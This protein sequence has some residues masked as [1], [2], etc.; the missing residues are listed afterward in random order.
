MT[1]EISLILILAVSQAGAP[2]ADGSL[3][4]SFVSDEAEAVLAL[5]AEQ[6][7]GASPAEAS[8][9]RLFDSRGYR[10]LKQREESMKRGFEDDEFR[11]FVLS[12][13]LRA[14][15]DALAGTLD[16]WRGASLTDAAGRALAYLP[17]GAKLAATIYPVIKPKSNSFVFDLDGDP[18]IFLYLDPDVT[19]AKFAN[20][21]AHELHH[22]GHHAACKDALAPAP[23]EDL[24]GPVSEA[25]GWLGAFGEGVAM[26]AAAGGPDV[27]PHA[28]SPDEDRA[29]WDS[30][31]SRFDQ[32]LRE[33]EA[34]LMDVATGRLS[35]PGKVREAGFRFFGVQGPWYTVGWRMAATVE[36]AYG[37]GALVESLCDM[38]RLLVLYNRA[39][40]P[41]SGAP[42]EE[43]R[44]LWSSG[45]LATLRASAP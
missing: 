34:F 26:L 35:D 8:W 14:R 11:S 28:V 18:S 29:R 12:P 10:R 36:T 7:A 27:H 45:L 16:A 22:V 43:G 38:R 42:P 13:E 41:A 5:L 4:V 15:E 37:R 1:R 24:P 44:A 20:T 39:M 6:R 31:L 25:V 19:S 17:P 3:D 32:D 40:A 23:G 9:T 33:V 21:V 30:D 2:P